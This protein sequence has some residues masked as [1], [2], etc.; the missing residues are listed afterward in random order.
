M[1]VPLI[2]FV[3]GDYSTS[4]TSA[5]DAQSAVCNKVLFNSSMFSAKLCRHLEAVSMI[6]KAAKTINGNVTMAA[7]M[8][9]YCIAIQ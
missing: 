5:P 1:G 7:H 8:V 9:S 3:S 4:D 6:T 2:L